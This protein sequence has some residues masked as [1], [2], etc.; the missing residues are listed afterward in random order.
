VVGLF[1]IAKLTGIYGLDNLLPRSTHFWVSTLNHRF[2]NA[3]AA[4]GLL[5]AAE[6]VVAHHSLQSEFDIE[7][8]D[9]RGET[10]RESH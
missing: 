4:V 7:K 5:L 2:G 1:V 6:R 9:Q 3:L 8:D 10:C